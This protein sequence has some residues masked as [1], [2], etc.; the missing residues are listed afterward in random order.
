[1]KNIVFV[2]PAG[3]LPVPAVNGGAIENLI[4]LLINENEKSKKFMFHIIMCKKSDDKTVYDYSKYNCTKFYDFYMSPLWYKVNRLINAGNKRL[5]YSLSLYSPFDKFVNKTVKKI[6][7]DF[8]I[9]EGAYTSAVRLLKKSVGKEKLIYHIHHQITYKIDLSKFFSKIICVSDFICEDWKQ[10]FKFKNDIECLVLKNAIDQNNFTKKIT[11]TDYKVLR[12]K[13]GFSEK[14]FVVI[15]T[16]RI[17]PVKGVLELFKAV[18]LLPNQDIKLMIVGSSASKGAK[19]T[20]Y[21]ENIKAL[22]EELGERVV[23]TGYVPNNELYKLYSISDLHVVPSLWEEA[24]GLVLIES[25]L[26]GLKQI[27]TNSGGISEYARK[28]ATIVIK[29]DKELVKNLSDAILKIYQ[30]NDRTKV[31]DDDKELTKENYYL[32]FTKLI[33]DINK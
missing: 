24:A 23:F 6:N 18:R 30:T 1:M 22:S 33:D 26:V 13:Y 17:I 5:N 19:D 20:P 28:D 9:Y 14:D 16:G 27:V 2:L 12:E 4:E 21:I 29:E 8:V 10:N 11:K 15:Y 3:S 32:R 25:R 31:C 7:P